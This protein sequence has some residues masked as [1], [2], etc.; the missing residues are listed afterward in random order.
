MKKIKLNGKLQLNKEVVSELNKQEMNSIQGGFTGSVGIRCTQRDGGC[1]AN[2]TNL[3]KGWACNDSRATL[4]TDGDC[5]TGLDE[6][7]R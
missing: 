1:S 2:E 3:S 7:I 4:C 6:Q 5:Q